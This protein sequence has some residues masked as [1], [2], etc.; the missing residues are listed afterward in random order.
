MR[1]RLNG[2]RGEGRIMEALWVR[3]TE[4]ECKDGWGT[5]ELGGLPGT[6]AGFVASPEPGRWLSQVSDERP[7]DL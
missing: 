2:V 1:W 3:R 4:G 6:E 7:R 5:G